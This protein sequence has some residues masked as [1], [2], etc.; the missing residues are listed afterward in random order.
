MSLLTTASIWTNDD[1]PQS[2]NRKRIPTMRKAIRRTPPASVDSS[3]GMPPTIAEIQQK[4]NDRTDR[5]NDLLSQMSA[6]HKDND[7]SGLA[8]FQP[9]EHPIL[10]KRTDLEHSQ[11]PDMPLPFPDNELQV[12]PQAVRA[13]PS[14]RPNSD[15]STVGTQYLSSYSV[16]PSAKRTLETSDPK[17]ME[18][19]NYLIHML[20]QQQNEKT[21]HITEEF[22][23]YMFL[24]VFIIFVV[25]SFSRGGKY[26]R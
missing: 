7:G 15:V 25:D 6:V 4:T 5:I 10:Q 26:V 11:P 17:L 21:N 3:H 18:K 22:V 12:P 2:E 9:L 8:D 14:Y 24:G 13:P 16:P 19:L 1:D 23:L 20:E